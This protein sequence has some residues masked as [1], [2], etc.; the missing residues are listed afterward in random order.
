MHPQNLLSSKSILYQDHFCCCLIIKE[1][2]DAIR[3]SYK[4][5]PEYTGPSSTTGIVYTCTDYY[6]RCVLLCVL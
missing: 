4:D 1:L 3:V 2:Q 5:Y 6:T